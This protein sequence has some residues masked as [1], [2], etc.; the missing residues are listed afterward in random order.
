MLRADRTVIDGPTAAD[1]RQEYHTWLPDA[2]EAVTL[3]TAA[4]QVAAD[5]RLDA[6]A[7]AAESRGVL[8]TAMAAAGLDVPA[9]AAEIGWQPA[10]LEARLRGETPLTIGEYATIEAAIAALR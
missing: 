2:G 9:L 6:Q 4:G 7:L 5:T 8:L 1:R 10:H 3:Q